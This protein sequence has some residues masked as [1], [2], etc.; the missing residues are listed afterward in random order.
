MNQPQPELK[1]K[2]GLGESKQE[3]EMEMVSDDEQTELEWR[4]VICPHCK[5]CVKFAFKFDNHII[6]WTQTIL[7]ILTLVSVW[8]QL[9]LT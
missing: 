2:R 5:G 1:R 9:V 8:L 6:N 7:Q 4:D 3:D